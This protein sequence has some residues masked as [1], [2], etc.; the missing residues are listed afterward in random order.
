MTT[1]IKTFLSEGNP[2]SI[3]LKKNIL[4]SFFLKGINILLTL[5][6]VPLTL[7]FLNPTEYGIWL[8]LSSIM[9]WIN[10]FDIGL[11]NGLRNK[12]AEA[13]ANKDDLLGQAYVSTTFALLSILTFSLFLIFVVIE[14]FLDWTEILNVKS[15]ASYN[16]S[17]I[18]IVVFIF[19]CLQFIFKLVGIILVADQKP[20]FN[21]L[22][23]VIGNALSL[24]TIFILSRTVNGSLPYVAYT[25]SATPVAVLLTAYLI[26]FRGRYSFL[27]PKI[28]AVDFAYTKDL[29]GLGVKFFILQI[30]SLIIFSTS[31]IIITQLFGPEKV[32]LYNIAFKYFCIVTMAFN[33]IITPMWTAITDA[34]IK[35]DIVWIKLSV[36][37]MGQIWVIGTL[38]A[39]LMVAL[40]NFAYKIWVGS[41]IH[42]PL[43]Y[44][45]ALGI[46]VTISNWNNIFAFF[47][48]GVGKIKLSLYTSIIQ[49]ALYLPLALILGKFWGVLGV[50][51]AINVVLILSS[52]LSPIQYHKIITKSAEGI[53]NT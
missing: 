53:W 29:L 20:A 2:R 32:T 36:K 48:N 40:S 3:K 46:F 49:A 13:L 41:E 7:H 18:V 10:F 51:L 6:L 9:I 8:T 1:V 12:L 47:L 42:I 22:I 24:L 52:V 45:I 30:A 14:P 23:N 37:R 15:S 28:R 11:G 25:F 26:V 44:S 33:I 35:D 38:V 4:A 34:F 39:I 16:F 21:D 50:V 17:T 5:L 27:K 19:F 31:N 43:E